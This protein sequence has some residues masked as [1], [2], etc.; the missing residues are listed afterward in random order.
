MNRSDQTWLDQMVEANAAFVDRVDVAK[1][2]VARQPG[3]AVITCMDPRVNLGSIGIS[4][5]ASDGKGTS[6]VR[7]IRTLGAM[8]DYRSLVVGVFLAGFQEIAL[9][10]HTDCGCCLA[11]SKTHIIADRMQGRL[12]GKTGGK[13][14]L[15]AK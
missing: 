10:V 1:L 5:F 7:I 12:S 3:Q 2:P 8:A 4:G 13:S 14:N 9:L 15:P 6:S 11:H